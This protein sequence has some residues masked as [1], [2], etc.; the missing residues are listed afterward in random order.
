MTRHTFFVEKTTTRRPVTG[1]R[2]DALTFEQLEGRHL[3]ALDLG[4]IAVSV[5]HQ[6]IDEAG[7]VQQSAVANA[8]VELFRDDGDGVFDPAEEGQGDEWLTSDSSDQL[9]KIV[10]SALDEGVYWLRQLKQSIGPLELDERVS[11]AIIVSAT[12]QIVDSFDQGDVSLTGVTESAFRSLQISKVLGGERDVSLTVDDLQTIASLQVSQESGL[13]FGA[14][15]ARFVNWRAIWDGQGGEYLAVDQSGLGGVDLRAGD[16]RGF[17]VELPELSREIFVRMKV[18]AIDGTVYRAQQL[19][20]PGGNSDL[21]FDFDSFRSVANEGLIQIPESVIANA[22][23]VE[24][25]I[26]PSLPADLSPVASLSGAITKVDTI[27]RIEID[28]EFVNSVPISDLSVR[29][30]GPIDHVVGSTAHYEITVSNA[31]PNNVEQ[32]VV[33]WS[34]PTG[35]Y[36]DLNDSTL[37]GDEWQVGPLQVGQE[38]TLLLP[39]RSDRSLLL[40]QS[41][42]TFETFD[43]SINSDLPDPVDYNNSSVQA[44]YL[45]WA[46]LSLELSAS[47]L[48]PRVG[49]SLEFELS[50][51]NHGISNVS[52][53][54]IKVE[55][56]AGL[57]LEEW[58]GALQGQ[59]LTLSA[60]SAMFND[61]PTIFRFQAR[62]ISI[63]EMSV[64]AEIV[65]ADRLDPDSIFNNGSPAEDDWDSVN[66]TPRYANLALAIDA[67]ESK[68]DI[69]SDL[70]LSVIVE[71]TGWFP[72][73]D[74]QVQLDLPAGMTVLTAPAEYD[75]ATRVWTIDRLGVMPTDRSLTLPLTIGT[76]ATLVTSTVT[77]EVGIVATLL[78]G[79]D[80]ESD[81][82]AETRIQ[83]RWADLSVEVSTNRPRPMSH[84]KVQF[85]IV[86]RND[87]NSQVNDIVLRASLIDIATDVA[88]IVKDYPIPQLAVGKSESLVWEIVVEDAA[89]KQVVVELIQANLFD[90]DSTVGNHST[91]EDDQS[92]L[93]LDP[94]VADLSLVGAVSEDR[95]SVGD[96]VTFTIEVL[97]SGPD[98]ADSVLVEFPLPMH[99]Y[100]FLTSIATNGVYDFTTGLW[101]VPADTARQQLEIVARVLSPRATTLV[102]EITSSTSFDPDSVPGDQQAE[103]DRAEILVQ[104]RWADLVVDLVGPASLTCSETN[105]GFQVLLENQGFVE[106]QNVTVRIDL[107]EGYGQFVSVQSLG[108]TRV[109]GDTIWIELDALKP[110]VTS[111]WLA[112]IEIILQGDLESPFSVTALV[113][114]TTFELDAGNNSAELVVRVQTLGSI[115][116]YVWHDQNADNVRDDDEAGVVGAVVFLDMNANGIWDE[117][118]PL[119]ITLDNDPTTQSNL[120]SGS[121][122]F[123]NIK[124]GRYLIVVQADAHLGVPAK[125]QSNVI[126]VTCGAV[127]RLEIA[128]AFFG[129]VNFYTAADEPERAI[130]A[131]DVPRRHE[132]LAQAVPV[133]RPLPI[134][135]GAGAIQRPTSTDPMEAIPP[136][137]QVSQPMIRLAP[138]VA[139]IDAL[140]L[141]DML[142]PGMAAFDP[143]EQLR[144]EIEAPPTVEDL[145]PPSSKTP[146]SP[147]PVEPESASNWPWFIVV[148]L[149]I[150]L[151]FGSLMALV[152]RRRKASQKSGLRSP[153]QI[154]TDS[155]TRLSFDDTTAPLSAPVDLDRS[156]AAHN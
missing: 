101:T 71:N 114:S 29:V 98:P 81:N 60:S 75:Q 15:P 77:G 31:G 55:L 111:S 2:R 46:D 14:E 124:E 50:L 112:T 138:P 8:T 123:D 32:A 146:A 102:A 148:V 121:F 155:D 74:V 78:S 69:Q 24:L 54:Q 99:E 82:R 35:F 64:T 48:T 7:M 62:V 66:V 83:P 25:E 122:R 119:R 116:G 142:G 38:R 63:L 19:V 95:P 44:L 117:G 135:I 22:G 33:H 149:G 89:D 70:S 3:F 108:F 10:F 18:H 127:S 30:D 58:D 103:D 152:F 37:A 118:E 73:Q 86:T 93:L 49:D 153:W 79:D 139:D 90:P 104:P 87:G 130:D 113:T 85:S 76:D 154:P 156:S 143:G 150:I 140:F 53:V 80:F 5:Q 68:V 92:S 151:T 110:D 27:G 141:D 132:P 40:S 72:M 1:L 125:V 56:P 65:D 100:Q 131:D 20:S 133:W 39:L 47:D 109:L 120:G 94:L 106:A 57:E 12:K 144:H 36:A 43:V 34:L 91:I 52:D 115:E 6:T 28:T 145:I 67:L 21:L 51:T 13:M 9:G 4:N 129:I 96:E 17:R 136:Q 107:P 147:S 42:P 11:D 97:N 16:A 88:L 45:Q 126:Q 23:A 137:L 128:V 84:E 59:Q 105:V 61:P 134:V 41:P 26:L